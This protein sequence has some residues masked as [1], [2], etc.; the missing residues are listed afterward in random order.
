M[1]DS[2]VDG[3]E[4]GTI[5]EE[6]LPTS[7]ERLPQISKSSILQCWQSILHLPPQIPLVLDKP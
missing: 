1:A 4:D 6:T 3:L 7:L 2:L 5:V